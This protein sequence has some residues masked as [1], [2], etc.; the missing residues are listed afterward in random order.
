MRTSALRAGQSS[1]CSACW[2]PSSLCI[3][4]VP[5]SGKHLDERRH[6]AAAIAFTLALLAIIASIPGLGF[7]TVGRCC[8][9]NGPKE[10][11][12]G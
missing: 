10:R 3:L 8:V 9:G 6:K 5:V 4:A 2:S 7:P 1:T 12:L 11:G